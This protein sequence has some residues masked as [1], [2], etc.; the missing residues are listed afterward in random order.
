MEKKKTQN[1]TTSQ[2]GKLNLTSRVQAM[3]YGLCIIIIKLDPVYKYNE[4]PF[5]E[6]LILTIWK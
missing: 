1:F 5:F 6:K 2:L 4:V 3:S